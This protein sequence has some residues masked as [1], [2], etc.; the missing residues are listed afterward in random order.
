MLSAI[1]KLYA[2]IK[3]LFLA[4]ELFV[5]KFLWPL[6]NRTDTIECGRRI[7]LSNAFKPLVCPSADACSIARVHETKFC[8]VA[9]QR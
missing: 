1:N 8:H 9:L 7:Y 6:N 2:G 3:T 4:N 5:K